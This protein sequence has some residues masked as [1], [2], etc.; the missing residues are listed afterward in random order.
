LKERIANIITAPKLPGQDSILNGT[1]RRREALA[2]RAKQGTGGSALLSDLAGLSG[3]PMAACSPCP[4]FMKARYFCSTVAASPRP[5]TLSVALM[6]RC[7]ESGSCGHETCND[8]IADVGGDT[9]NRADRVAA[10][11]AGLGW[12]SIFASLARR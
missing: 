2:F 7:G 8:R 3:C 12:V 10:A 9:R 6:A 5:K 11:A 1:V 4:G